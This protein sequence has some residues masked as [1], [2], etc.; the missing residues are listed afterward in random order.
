MSSDQNLTD[1]NE[2]TDKMNADVDYQKV[3]NQ[4]DRQDF[5]SLEDKVEELEEEVKVLKAT[6]ALMQEA[7]QFASVKYNK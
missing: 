7:M 4:L 6:I 3:V 2:F 1:Y 5:S